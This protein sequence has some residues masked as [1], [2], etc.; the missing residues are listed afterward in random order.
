ML[1]GHGLLSESHLSY[2]FF[3]SPFALVRILCPPPRFQALILF[4][5][6]L[7]FLSQRVCAIFFGLIP[8]TGHATHPP[9]GKVFFPVVV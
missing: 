1:G 6:T 2:L 8:G 9:L 3:S 5:R 7:G 4:K